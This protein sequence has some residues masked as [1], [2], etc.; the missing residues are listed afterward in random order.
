WPLGDSASAPTLSPCVSSRYG[1][2]SSGRLPWLP[3]RSWLS[4]CAYRQQAPCQVWRLGSWAK[5][6]TP[7]ELSNILVPTDFSVDAEQAFQE[8][9]ALAP[10]EH[11]QVLLLH[12]L[13][14]REGMWTDVAW[15]I[16]RQ[17]MHELQTEDRKSTRLNS[18]HQITSYAGF[19]LK[20]KNPHSPAIRQFITAVFAFYIQ[21]ANM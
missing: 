21:P 5:K 10:R 20:K 11:A 18:S 12:V 6:G 3:E 19:C 1:T 9:L 4:A 17:L 2:R 7:M 16:R 15:P 14:R 13:L 8:A